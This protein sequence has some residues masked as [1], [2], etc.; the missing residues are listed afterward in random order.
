VIGKAGREIAEADAMDHVGGYT[1]VNDV[2]A[3]SHRLQVL[4]GSIGP[5][6]MAK[7][8]DTFAPMGP[9]L[10]TADEIPEPHNLQVS[11]FLNGKLMTHA[12]TREAVFKIPAL[13]SY[14]SNIFELR[15]GDLILT[16]SPPPQGKPTFL[17]AGDVVRI[18]IERLGVLENPVL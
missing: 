16:G 2:T 9:W 6:M 4:V 10:T 12:N 15:P 5:Y 17:G 1:I 7:T 14:L 18:E 13:I 11:Q 8:F 3:F